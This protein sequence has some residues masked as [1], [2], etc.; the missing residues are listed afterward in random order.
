MEAS[1]KRD[2][3][4]EA[5]VAELPAGEHDYFDRKSGRLFD[6]ERGDLL[7]T[8][9]KALSAFSNTGGGHLVLGV[10]D[11]GS[12]DGVPRTI[13]S[14]TSTRE[15]LEQKIPNLLAYALT[16]FRVHVV[17]RDQQSSLIPL[18]RDVIVI[19]VGDSALA[20]RRTAGF[21]EGQ[22][23]PRSP[24]VGLLPLIGPAARRVVLRRVGVVLALAALLRPQDDATMST[25]ARYRSEWYQW[26]R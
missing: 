25:G 13:S 6:G 5:D 15:W 7:G 26:P 18:D 4:T 11:D 23:P 19:D 16:D 20:P 8:I 3:W 10:A 2:R 1:P 24:L 17:E 9:A 21:V 14:R 22:Q 12:F